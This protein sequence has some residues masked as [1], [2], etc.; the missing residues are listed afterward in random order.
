MP[1]T[2]CL[3]VGC[4]GFA[5]Y[6]GR[7]PRHAPERERETHRPARPDP[8]T[9]KPARPRIYSTKRWRMLRLKVL[10]RDPIC[11]ECRAELSTEADHVIAI[12]DGGD[13]WKM[14]NLQG[15]CSSCHGRKTQAEVGARAYS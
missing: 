3:E 7:C 12:E 9:G 8:E 6:R 14:S 10:R 4:P 11:V 15:L 5:E 1:H 13:P 2:P